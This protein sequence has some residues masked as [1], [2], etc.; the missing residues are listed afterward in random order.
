M[1]PSVQLWALDSIHSQ[2]AIFVKIRIYPVLRFI[3]AEC[4]SNPE[5][6][7]ARD[8]LGGRHES[9]GIRRNHSRIHGNKIS[10]NRYSH[11]DDLWTSDMGTA[12]HQ[13][14]TTN[15]KGRVKPT[16]ALVFTNTQRLATQHLFRKVA[17]ADTTAF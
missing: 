4:L 14:P 3:R 11:S 6:W 7:C 10:T 8:S 16:V 5:C 15:T 17:F 2:C 12:C 13:T 9:G 1:D